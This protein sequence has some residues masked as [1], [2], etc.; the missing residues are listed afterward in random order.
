VTPGGRLRWY[1][2]VYEVVHGRALRPAADATLSAQAS[3][4]RKDPVA[5]AVTDANG[6]AELAFDIP[7]DEDIGA[8]FEL[9][10]TARTR[11][12]A[13]QA[14]VPVEPGPRYRIARESDRQV[15]EPGEMVFV[16]GRVMDATRE[17]PAAGRALRVEALGPGR[18]SL[19]AAQT[20][21]TDDAGLF[22][23]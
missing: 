20:L 9:G 3:F 12:A 2:T 11:Q 10:V 6:H 19:A 8:S 18:R 14:G 13:R 17:R 22:H 4:H 21:T 1:V 5:K 16:W 23:M 15:F 7:A